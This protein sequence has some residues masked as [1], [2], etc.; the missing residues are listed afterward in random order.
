MHPRAR[1]ALL[2]LLGIGVLAALLAY[3]GPAEVVRALRAASPAYLG[4]AVLAYAVF[5][6]LRG[7]RWKML[8]SYSAPDV[9]LSSTTSLTAVGWLANSILPLKGGDVL[10]AALLARRERVGLAAS[11]ATV[12]L[13][14]VLDVLG[15]ALVAAMGLLLLPH[16][17]ELPTGLE[18]ALA[19]V[20]ILPLLSIGILL[21]LVR[22][23]AQAVRVAGSLLRPLGKFGRKLV[24]F[25]DTVLAGLAALAGKPRLLAKL[26]PM[27][28]AV[29][30]AQT[31]I[32]TFLVKAFLGPTLLLAFAGSALFLMSFVVSI[33]PGNV[34]TYEAAF[35]A[36]FVALGTP[37]D[38][39]IP[40]GVLTHVVTTLT[41]AVLG[42]I[43]MAAMG[44]TRQRAEPLPW[45]S[46]QPHAPRA[47]TQ[48][49]GSP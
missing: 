28:I 23:R 30:L 19:I 7:L 8:F 43:G 40:A 45:T 3:V 36:I 42:G 13:E 17:A 29:A 37:A 34:G 9:R 4:L 14:R 39:A 38:V 5:F 11:A 49:G 46:G 26:L 1:A 24:E 32:F 35:A 20:W 6:L 16:A 27:T 12:G 2:F 21:A 15:V 33:T 25:G 41:V 10:R 22:W 47:P 31:L 44:L 18:R 48:G